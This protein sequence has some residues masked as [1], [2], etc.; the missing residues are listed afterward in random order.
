MYSLGLIHVVSLQEVPRCCLAIAGKK[1]NNVQGVDWHEK[2]N[3]M[4]ANLGRVPLL[5][6]AQGSIGQ[7]A[8]INFYVA[9]ECGLMGTSSFE[10]AQIVNFN[11]HLN[12]LNAAY[13]KAHP[14]G[15]EPDEEK[16]KD[17]FENSNAN[18]YAGPANRAVSGDRKLFPRCGR[19]SRRWPTTR[20]SLRGSKSAAPRVSEEG[21]AE[22]EPRTCRSTASLVAHAGSRTFSH[23]V[24]SSHVQHHTRVVRSLAR[25][26]GL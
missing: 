16:I 11:E 21:P 18:D 2:G 5:E 13:R 19:A 10:A 7:S 1:Y 14:Y 17:F 9:S 20:T 4:D 22:H 25:T 24:L 15:T 23:T 6:S 8:A 26:P 3:L 12:E